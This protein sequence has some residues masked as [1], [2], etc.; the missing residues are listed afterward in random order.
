MFLSLQSTGVSLVPNPLADGSQMGTLSNC[1]RLNGLHSSAC[2]S[3]IWSRNVW[4]H[5][6]MVKNVLHLLVFGQEKKGNIWSLE[7]QKNTKGEYLEK[8]NCYMRRK[9]VWKEG[10]R[11]P[12]KG[13]QRLN[14]KIEGVE[15]KEWPRTFMKKKQHLE[16]PSKTKSKSLISLPKWLQ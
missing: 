1:C 12:R 14:K 9:D 16:I 11:R 15:G 8:E 13:P 6:V 5:M 7:E 3:F 2:W 4:Q 10:N